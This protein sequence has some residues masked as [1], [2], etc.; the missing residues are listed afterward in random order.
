MT[1]MVMKE[2]TEALS[3]YRI[4]M[5]PRQ[6]VAPSYHKKAV[7]LI[8]VLAGSGTVRL[9]RRSVR[10]RRNDTL[11]IR[12]PTPHGFEAGRS[13]MTMLAI[14]SPRVDSRTDIY[15][16]GKGNAGHAATKVLSGRWREGGR[17]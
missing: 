8:W 17:D 5:G 1:G 10:M 7:E 4:E 9:G 2:E 12:P 11:F 6:V 15:P 16:A 13:G 3:V 14:L